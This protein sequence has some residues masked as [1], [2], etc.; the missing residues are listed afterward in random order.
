MDGMLSIGS[1][2]FGRMASATLTVAQRHSHTNSLDC[3]SAKHFSYKKEQTKK[4]H[5]RLKNCY[6]MDSHLKEAISSCRFFRIV[7]T[8]RFL[9]FSLS[10]LRA[11]TKLY[12]Q[13]VHI[14]RFHEPFF[15]L[16]FFFVSPHRYVI[17]LP[18]S[19][20]FKVKVAK[21]SE[22]KITWPP[23]PFTDFM[24]RDA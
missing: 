21:E 16:R 24:I 12:W 14:T 23:K 6:V 17:D 22:V 19:A 3:W 10:L 13:Q 1:V 7:F 2:L 15:T 20:Y 9:L 11:N 8:F 4:W 5:A 18:Q